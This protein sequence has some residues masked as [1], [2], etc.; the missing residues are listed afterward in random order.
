LSGKLSRPTDEQLK[1][2]TPPKPPTRERKGLFDTEWGNIWFASVNK[3]PAGSV[4]DKRGISVTDME[5]SKDGKWAA[6]CDAATNDVFLLDGAARKKQRLV[7]GWAY[8]VKWLSAAES[9][10]KTG[11]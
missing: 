9:A 10:N 8:D 6:L 2:A 3:A 4:L 7:I 11:P 5:I 1:S